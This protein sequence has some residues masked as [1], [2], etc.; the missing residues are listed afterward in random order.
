MRVMRRWVR[1][2]GRDGLYA[3]RYVVTGLMSVVPLGLLY[4]VAAGE[5]LP[6]AWPG[7]IYIGIVAYWEVAIWRIALVGVYVSDFG[8]KVRMVTRTRVVPW[9]RIVRPWAGQAAHY[10]AW[11][12]WISVRDPERDSERDIETPLWRKGSRARHRNRIL[13]PP[14]EFA[15]TLEA[16]HPQRSSF[17][18]SR[19]RTGG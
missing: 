3:L 5:P 15:A 9:S 7:I 18:A 12:I 16:L 13:L 4:D 2:Y 19:A 14:D 17:N 1:P 10:D 6:F 8:V 11:Q